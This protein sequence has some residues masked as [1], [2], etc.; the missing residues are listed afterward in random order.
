MSD[1]VNK[2]ELEDININHIW[3]LRGCFSRYLQCAINT[4]SNIF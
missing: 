3:K 1:I 2:S 4:S